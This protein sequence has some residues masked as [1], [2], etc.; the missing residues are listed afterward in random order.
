MLYEHRKHS[1]E[2]PVIGVNT[3]L[4][5]E[6]SGEANSD[7]EL[8]RG[9]DDEKQ[10]QLDH[11]RAFQARNADEAPEA[12]RRLQAAARA[13]ENVFPELVEAARVCSLGQIT[14]ALFEVGGQYRRNM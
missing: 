12:L 5:P 7:V 6:A 2:L 13:R 9:S 4:A 8:M 11:L 10:H 3:F 1:G 14:S